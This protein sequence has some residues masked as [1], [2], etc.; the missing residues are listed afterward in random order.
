[1]PSTGSRTLGGTILR[2]LA[3]ACLLLALD[4]AV[5][6]SGF[7]MQHVASPDSAAGHVAQVLRQAE[8]VPEDTRPVLVFGDSRIGEGFSGQAATARAAEAGSGLTFFGTSS[9][10]ATPRVMYFFLRGIDPDRRRFSAVV[11]GLGTLHD[12]EPTDVWN[13]ERDIGLIHSFLRPGDIPDLF[14]DSDKPAFRSYALRALLFPGTNYTTDLRRLFAEG[15]KRLESVRWWRE[16]GNNTL[17]A[18]P[19]IDASLEGLSYDFATERLEIPPSAE[20]RGMAGWLRTYATDLST[21]HRYGTTDNPPM[22]AYRYKWLR[23]IA[24]RYRDAGVPVY[25]VQLPRGPLHGMM[26]PPGE[27]TGA[28]KRLVDEGL[29]RLLPPA[30]AAG[31]ERPELFADPLHLNRVGRIAFSRVLA[32]G[33]IGAAQVAAR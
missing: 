11:I 21:V 12:A 23:R 24:E 18:Y 28:V 13:W 7:Y 1:L 15:P 22:T 31:L 32:D 14:A 3:G 2:L 25:L 33:M 10:G 29:V 5:F 17:A 30:L 9:S 8:A 19:G 16:H 6:R 20:A 27:P 4:A 26:P